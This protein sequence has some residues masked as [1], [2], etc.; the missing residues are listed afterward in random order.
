M[1]EWSNQSNSLVDNKSKFLLRLRAGRGQKSL[2]MEKSVSILLDKTFVW[3]TSEVNIFC[4]LINHML[5]L[6]CHGRSH[7]RFNELNDLCLEI[8]TLS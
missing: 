4:C 3:W 7:A 6:M 5:H 1:V 8:V 2:D